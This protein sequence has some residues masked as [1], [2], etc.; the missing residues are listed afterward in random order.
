[1]IFV[2]DYFYGYEAG[3]QVHYF[4]GYAIFIT[5]ISIF[6]YAFSKKHEK[7]PEIP[8]NPLPQTAQ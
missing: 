8:S 1:M 3:A 6:F 2:T 5:W 7:T 4:I